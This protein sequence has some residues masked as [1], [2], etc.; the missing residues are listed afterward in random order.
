MCTY[1]IN[2]AYSLIPVSWFFLYII[3]IHLTRARARVTSFLT[4]RGRAHV[5][6]VFSPHHQHIL[7]DRFHFLNII[8]QTP[9]TIKKSVMFLSS[10]VHL[11]CLFFFFF[12]IHACRV[13]TIYYRSRSLV[14]IISLLFVYLLRS[15]ITPF[16]FYAPLYDNY[17]HSCVLMYLY[18]KI[19]K[20]YPLVGL[21]KKYAVVS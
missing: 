20:F 18:I 13:F 1:S 5:Y 3:F 7:K 9:H 12:K 2:H 10:F 8:A 6:Y 17:I 4:N 16:I 15:I 11:L 14:Y 19:Q 21:P